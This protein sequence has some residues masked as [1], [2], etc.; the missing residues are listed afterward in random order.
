MGN[1]PL[2]MCFFCYQDGDQP[3]GGPNMS[4]VI[5]DAS[6]VVPVSK[7]DAENMP[8]GDDKLAAFLGIG[9]GDE[10]NRGEVLG[11]KIGQQE[12]NSTYLKA[13]GKCGGGGNSGRESGDSDMEVSVGLAPR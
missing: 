3:G 8:V 10:G 7:Q 12:S 11:H 1:S 9:E 5:I 2:P 4:P 6:A 13:T